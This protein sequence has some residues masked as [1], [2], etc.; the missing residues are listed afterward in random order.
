MPCDDLPQVRCRP[1]FVLHEADRF[2]AQQSLLAML[3]GLLALEIDTAIEPVVSV[4]R[5]GPLMADLAALP[6]LTLLS[7]T[8]L[9]W[10]KHS[11]R[12]GLQRLGDLLGLLWAMPGR[13]QKLA[14]AIRTQG[15]TVVHVNSSVSLE[16]ALA[17]R[18]AGVPLVWHIREL[19][20]DPNPAYW[21]LLGRPLTAWVIR[22]LAHR[23]VCISRPVAVGVFGEKALKT[24]PPSCVIVP[25]AVDVPIALMSHN[26]LAKTDPH[27]PFQLG[28]LGRITPQKGLETLLEALAGLQDHP[29]ELC[30]AGR[31]VDAAYEHHVHEKITALGIA[32]RVRWEGETADPLSFLRTLDGLAVPS[33]A[34]AFG[35]VVIEALMCGTP[36][37]A[38]A[39][40]GIPEI[41]QP[42]GELPLGTLV[43]P[44][45]AAG[46]EQALAQWLADPEGRAELAQQ[47]QQVAL[48]RYT[49]KAIATQVLAVYQGVS[50]N[51]PTR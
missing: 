16:G 5:T 13:V 30:I 1:F 20:H 8:R 9:P 27:T 40:G 14:T 50:I 19:I 26:E 46:W 45:T 33:R 29:W 39:A 21:P 6:R 51:Y 10:V 35:R 38:S 34:E 48:T 4:A 36:V 22:R 37:I 23:V 47:G 11:P 49:P 32:N 18:M 7:H 44:P 25:N 31:F 17:A 15:A 41:L 24:L 28:F 42:A 12:R 2:G 3:K 43:H